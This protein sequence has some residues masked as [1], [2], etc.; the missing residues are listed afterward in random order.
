MRPR[1]D[2]IKTYVHDINVSAL[3]VFFCQSACCAC[4]PTHYLAALTPLSFVYYLLSGKSDMRPC[5]WLNVLLLAATL[6]RYNDTCAKAL[7]ML[8]SSIVPTRFIGA[9]AA[10]AAPG[11]NK[12]CSFFERLQ[13]LLIARAPPACCTL[14]PLTGTPAAMFQMTVLTLEP[15]AR[16]VLVIHTP[17]YIGL[18]GPGVPALLAAV[19]SSSS[20]SLSADVVDVADATC[21]TLPAS[22]VCHKMPA[23]QNN[24]TCARITSAS[25]ESRFNPPVLL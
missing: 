20:P 9:A 4:V 14:H 1:H 11:C 24:L 3:R 6:W 15:C 5:W 25:H 23:Q 18:L 16:H 21:A 12:S 8:M 2:D 22:S 7:L 10:S 13:M 19:P 17:Q